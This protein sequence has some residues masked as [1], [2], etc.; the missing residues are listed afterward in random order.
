M[1]EL[2]FNRIK[3]MLARKGKQNI[4]L[5]EDLGVDTR[6]VSTWCTNSSQPPIATLFRIAQILNME[7]GDL[8]TQ[9][10]ELK[11]VTR[12]KNSAKAKTAKNTV[13]KNT[14]VKKSA[15]KKTLAR[16]KS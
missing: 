3:E 15:S 9:M 6:T 11:P 2:T 16:K 10:A 4:A 7:A 14:G 1:S 8:L 12:K 13:A 5:A